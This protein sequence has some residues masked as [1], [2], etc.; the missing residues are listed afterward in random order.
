MGR[1]IDTKKGNRISRVRI[2]IDKQKEISKYVVNTGI[3]MLDIWE[4]EPL[5]RLSIVYLSSSLAREL[6]ANVLTTLTTNG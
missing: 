2:K 3:G 1:Q 5:L 6:Y 4:Y